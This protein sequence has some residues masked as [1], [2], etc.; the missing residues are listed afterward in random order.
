MA[1][2]SAT[3]MSHVADVAD[4]TEAK[5]VSARSPFVSDEESTEDYL[6]AHD[7]TVN[8]HQS[9]SARYEYERFFSDPESASS[10]SAS[11]IE[12]QIEGTETKNMM[13]SNN[14]QFPLLWMMAQSTSLL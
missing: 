7:N 4:T 2:L 3:K 6:Q 13:G 12:T 14:F 1:W 10:D 9:F 8:L 5:S 11:S